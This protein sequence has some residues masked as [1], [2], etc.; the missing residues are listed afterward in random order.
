M[1]PDEKEML[2]NK[3]A[4]YVRYMQMLEKYNAVFPVLLFE[5]RQLMC[6]RIKSLLRQVFDVLWR[7]KES[8][9]QKKEQIPLWYT[10]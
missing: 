9:H 6:V 5:E 10:E 2:L 3:N 4:F 1:L 8:D 7:E